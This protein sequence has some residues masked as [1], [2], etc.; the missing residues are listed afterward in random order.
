MVEPLPSSTEF[1]TQYHKKKKKKRKK[2]QLQAEV[3]AQLIISQ[4]L[5]GTKKFLNYV[6][7]MKKISLLLYILNSATGD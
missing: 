7:P 2:K 3:R 4:C 5:I 6:L 1:K